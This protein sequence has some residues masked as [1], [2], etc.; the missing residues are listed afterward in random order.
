MHDEAI[1]RA[2]RRMQEL[3]SEADLMLMFE[4]LPESG[5]QRIQDLL[6]GSQDILI[7]PSFLSTRPSFAE[8][9]KLGC[10]IELIE[11]KEEV[12]QGQKE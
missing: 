11:V 6:A 3:A 12:D 8:L 9:Q 10:K 7:A 4:V 5:P 2:Q 1:H